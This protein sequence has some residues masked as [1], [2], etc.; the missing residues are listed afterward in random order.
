MAFS[1]NLGRSGIKG[2]QILLAMQKWAFFRMN[3]LFLCMII[4]CYTLRYSTKEYSISERFFFC[5]DVVF[6]DFYSWRA[7]ITGV[8]PQNVAR[9][10]TFC[11]SDRLPPV[12]ASDRFAWYL[13]IRCRKR[14]KSQINAKSAGE[15]PGNLS[16][17]RACTSGALFFS[18]SRPCGPL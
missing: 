12:S 14:L 10:K 18:S 11:H 15:T 9:F 16:R 8:Y 5:H 4:R 1:L 7:F 3:M 2:D 13:F 6:S 17:A